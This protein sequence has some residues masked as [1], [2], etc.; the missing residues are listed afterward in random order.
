MRQDASIAHTRATTDI[1]E[2]ELSDTGV[3]LKQEGQRL[4]N[5]TTGTQD[6]DLGGL[7]MKGKNR[8]ALIRAERPRFTRQQAAVP[9]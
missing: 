6:G 7:R 5:A 1:I 3:Q 2:G 4:A 8:L 9:T